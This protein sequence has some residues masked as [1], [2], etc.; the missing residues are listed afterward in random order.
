[1]ICVSIGRTRHKMMMMEHRALAEQGAELV[2]LRL[3][4]LARIPD[5]PRLLQDRPTQVILTCRRKEDRGRWR[6]DEDAR[7]KLLRTAIVSEVDYVDLEDDVASQ[8]PRFG[9]T[10]RIVSYHNFDETP[11]NLEERHIHMTQL[12]P[13]IIKIVTMANSPA[14]CIRMLKLVSRSEIPTVGFCMGEFGIMTRILCGKYGA[15]FTY[16]TFDQERVMAPGQLP[17]AQMKDFY[18]YDQINEATQV[19]AVLGDP[20][21]HSL[22]PMLH[23][24]AFQH[25]GINA[26][27]IPVR[28]PRDAFKESLD[29]MDWLDIR[30][31]SVTIPH[32]SAARDYADDYDESVAKIGA[33]NT[34]YRT[35]DQLWHATN[36]DCRAAV[37][38]LKLVLRDGESLTGKK[39]IVIGAGGA[40]RA[41]VHGLLE[42]GAFVTIAN[43][44]NFKAENLA[45]E[46]DCQF[47]RWEH[48]GK[49]YHDL[50]VN[51]TPVGMYPNM[52]ET[53]FPDNWLNEGMIVFDTVYNPENTLL[54][55]QARERNCR[56]VSGLEMF[57]RQ[58]AVQFEKFT[59]I[60]PDLE[61]FRSTVRQSISAV[62]YES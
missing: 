35:A 24:R 30:G 50:L 51:C 2:E 43:R 6:F 12:D 10:K 22:S 17:Y 1:M 39:A 32:K 60:E 57:A 29:E 34:L 33:A 20:I 52:N 7:Q 41:I 55:K 44:T 47:I 46:F 53:P 31:Y 18:R 16:A 23:N 36:T 56:T 5:L 59:Y 40:A 9:K 42:E 28:V 54:I 45:Q 49:D 61:Q 19:F 14:D 62:N 8:I 15:P 37:D 11:N 27:Y 3:D 25:H 21:G 48:R 13:D 26:V 4:Y 58:A 38:S